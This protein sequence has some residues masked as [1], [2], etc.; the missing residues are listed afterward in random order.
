METSPARAPVSM[1]DPP[2]AR[3]ARIVLVV[4]AWLLPAS[5]LAGEALPSNPDAY[6]DQADRVR[7]SV[8]RPW[9]PATGRLGNLRRLNL[10]ANDCVVR[11]V[12]GNENRVLP[13]THEVTVVEESRILDTDPD[14]QP[15]PRDVTL[16][17]HGSD[18]CPGEGQCGVSVVEARAAPRLGGGSVCFTVQLATAHDVSLRGDGVDLLVEEL[19]QP[20][21]RVGVGGN[22]RQRIWFEGVDLG[23]LSIRINSQVQVGGTGTVDW[24]NA[25]SSNGSSVAWLHLFRANQTGVSATTTRTR[26]SVRT[27]PGT[28]AGYYQPARA[29][30]KLADLYPIEVDGPVEALEVPASRVSAKPITPATRDAAMALRKAVL[31]RAGPRPYIRA[32]DARLPTAVASAQALPRSSKQRVADVIAGLVPAGV[33]IDEVALW[34]HGGRIEGTAPDVATAEIVKQRLEASGEFSHAQVSFPRREGPVSLHVMAH[35]HCETPGEPSACLPADP[36]SPDRYTEAQLRA[37][38]ERSVGPT[39]EIRSFR[40]DGRKVHVEG[41]AASGSDPRAALGAF[42]KDNGMLRTSHT[43]Y[44]FAVPGGSEVRALLHLQCLAPPR[45]DGICT[46]PAASKP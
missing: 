7:R 3:R 16:A 8:D 44:G 2:S 18:P 37:Y 43:I 25:E 40:I 31:E 29:P 38:V 21:L 13:G 24:L 46:L 4:L 19:R 1:I 22:G 45:A 17:A 33:R 6:L 41:V 36:A 26:W 27:G 39:F 34:K 5:I 42:N 15:P 10:A 14:E 9:D 12:S 23:L 32:F 11:L 35:F 28:W 20:V 30:G